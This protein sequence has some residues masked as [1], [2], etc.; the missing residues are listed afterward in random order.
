MRLLVAGGAGFIGSN[1]IHHMLSEH[2]DIEIVNF[3][4]LTYA[5]NLDNLKDIE[6]DPRYSFV[7][8]D[9][10]DLEKLNETIKKFKITHVINF[11]AETHVDR[12]I[13]G[14]TKEFVLT[15]TLGVQM[16]LDAAN[17]NNIEKMV[18]VST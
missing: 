11:A 10:T 14:G 7:K 8:G 5:G 15:N 17:A 18:N 16:L 3:D 9:I 13:H 12:S 4:K 2:K 1:F 6:N